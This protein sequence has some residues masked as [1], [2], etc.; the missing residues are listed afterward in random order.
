MSDSKKQPSQGEKG[1]FFETLI[2][3]KTIFIQD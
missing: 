1:E 3:E 2:N